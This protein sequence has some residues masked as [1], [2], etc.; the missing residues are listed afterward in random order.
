M[1]IHSFVSDGSVFDPNITLLNLETTTIPCGYLDR[2][3]IEHMVQPIE[4]TDTRTQRL[5]IVYRQSFHNNDD[6]TIGNLM[7]PDIIDSYGNIEIGR[8]SCRERV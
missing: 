3:M 2:E 8:A 4:F 7:I 5:P 6:T 1:A